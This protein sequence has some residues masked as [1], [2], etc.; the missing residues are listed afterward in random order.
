MR[1]YLSK[2]EEGHTEAT[3]KAAPD[4]SGAQRAIQVLLDDLHHSHASVDG[5]PPAPIDNAL[6]LLHDYAELSKAQENLQAKGHDKTLDVI[7]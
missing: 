6:N 1:S 4:A 5:S 2:K 7:F 3:D